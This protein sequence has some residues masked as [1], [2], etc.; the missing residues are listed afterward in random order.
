MID[1]QPSAPYFCRMKKNTVSPPE[2]RFIDLH[3][4]SAA[5]DG[6]DSPAALVA[7]ANALHLAAIA[8]TDHDTLDG[9]DEAQAAAQ[10]CE[11]EFIRGCEISTATP[12]G[13][14][15][16]LGLWLSHDPQKLAPL[17]DTLKEVRRLRNTRNEHMVEKLRALGMDITLE[18]VQALAWDG[19]GVVGRPH[20]AQWLLQANKVRTR[21]EA[22]DRYLGSNGSIFTPRELIQPAQAIQLLL[23]AGA[24][25]SLAHPRLLRCSLAALS[26]LLKDWVPLGLSALEAYHSEHGAAE[27]R[28]CVT[29]ANQYHLLLT[30]GSDYHGAAKPGVELGCGK[31]S[32][33]VTR[34]V[35]D[36]LKAQREN[37]AAGCPLF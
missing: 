5:S 18:A 28:E 32:L 33:R 2:R 12:Y 23:F 3:T 4:H 22:F 9:L 16:F 29:L 20:F 8:L 7:K 13:E 31:G 27:E 34:F 36:K 30:G 1:I 21:K 26:D 10:N 15:H 37:G 17:Q 35:L 6:T 14:A 11:I 25:V 24:T 19:D